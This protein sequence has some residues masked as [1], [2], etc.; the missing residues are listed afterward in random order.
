MKKMERMTIV[1]DVEAPSLT[2]AYRKIYQNMKT[3]DCSEFSWEST[4][5]AYGIYGNEYDPDYVQQCRMDVFAGE[6]ESDVKSVSWYQ[7]RIAQLEEGLEIATIVMASVWPD[8]FLEVFTEDEI[9]DMV[10]RNAPTE[11]FLVEARMASL[12]LRSGDKS[13]KTTAN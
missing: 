1:I 3:L 10:R 5:E 12:L 4:D 7:E 13:D 2:E 9:K 8:M 11:D 6:N